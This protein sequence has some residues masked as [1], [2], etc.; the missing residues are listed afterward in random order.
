MPVISLILKSSLLGFGLAMDAFSVSVANGIANPKMRKRKGYLIAGTFAFF[1]LLMPLIGWAAI[2]FIKERFA[3]LD[4]CIP[5]AAFILLGFIGG[6]MIVEAIKEGKEAGEN[7]ADSNAGA[8]ADKSDSDAVSTSVDTEKVKEVTFKA[9]IVQGIA[10]SID[11]LSV[12]FTIADYGV[13]EAVSSAL[14]IGM[15]TF[16]ICIIGVFLGKKLGQ[17]LAKRATI[18]GGIVLIAIGIEILVKGLFF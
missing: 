1:Q 2:D 8:D 3:I 7:A 15:V 12:G 5:W 13:L 14:I 6:K 9:L 16:V 18:V 4:K 11:A 17:K 10:T